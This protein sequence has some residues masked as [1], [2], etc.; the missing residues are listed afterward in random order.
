MK[1]KLI[2]FIACGLLLG[3]L[4]TGCSAPA[5]TEEAETT[6]AAEMPLKVGMTVQSISNPIRAG[7]TSETKKAMKQVLTDIQDG[8]F[9]KN[10][11]LE[12]SV[13]CPNFH[14]MRKSGAEHSSEKVGQELR[15]L[16]SWNDGKKL[17][18][19]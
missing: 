11:L 18:D 4:F 12:N 19:N 16:Y 3:T 7:I 13:N 10:W 6:E 9:A 15:K 5:T 14:A 8:T 1:R 2:S 17:I